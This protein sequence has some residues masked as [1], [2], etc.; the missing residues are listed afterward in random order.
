MV[1]YALAN[2]RIAPAQAIRPRGSLASEVLGALR[3][4]ILEIVDVPLL[5]VMW[6]ESDAAGKHG[7]SL[8]AI[9]QDGT[10][11]MV[12][13][14]QRLT[15]VDLYEVVSRSGRYAHTGPVDMAQV[16]SKGTKEFGPDWEEFRSGRPP[17]GGV[18]PRLI[19]VALDIDEDVLPVFST[20][21]ERVQL[22][23][24]SIFDTNGVRQVSIERGSGP[25]A[26]ETVEF[27]PAPDVESSEETK[28]RRRG[29]REAQE[30]QPTL[31]IPATPRFTAFPG[32]IGSHGSQDDADD[33]TDP[34]QTLIVEAVEAPLAEQPQ[35]VDAEA[36]D[37]PTGRRS[38]RSAH[39]EQG[40]GGPREDEPDQRA[41]QNAEKGSQEDP[42]SQMKIPVI[43]AWRV[44]EDGADETPTYIS[45]RYDQ[46]V[47]RPRTE[48]L[49]WEKSAPKR[50]GKRRQP[51]TFSETTAANA[52]SDAVA[53]AA[54][55]ELLTP[56]GR[57]VAIASRSV[58]PLTL[59][60][61][62]NGSPTMAT[63]TSTGT[64]LLGHTSYQDPS[65][66]AAEVLGRNDVN[67]WQLWKTREGRL[68]GEL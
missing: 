25:S 17:L 48:Q 35:P 65:K 58:T 8:V 20:L 36:G 45:A 64:L 54:E 6:E 68:L 57:L 26:D 5:P 61:W 30:F 24:A 51:Q 39:R 47:K 60:I 16:Y 46:E 28:P 44:T 9:D 21:S 56:A 42:F 53:R 1:L 32:H 59:E 63:L 7:Q 62:K 52:S 22:L 18:S 27:R 43:P 55:R 34:A 33:V 29:R 12:N 37:R 23:S 19:V 10:V 49:L 11:V 67:G 31:T 14:R 13:L 40:Q 38:R 15:S 3:E 66:A 2:G 4:S 50:D 41:E